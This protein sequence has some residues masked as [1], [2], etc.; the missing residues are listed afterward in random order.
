M[1][2][3]TT[4][5]PYLR[6]VRLLAEKTNLWIILIATIVGVGGLFLLW[7]SIP[8]TGESPKIWQIFAQNI[9]V[10]LIV[11]V[12]ITFLWEFLGKRAFLNEILAKTRMAEEVRLAGIIG[13]TDSFH[14]IDMTYWESLFRNA[15]HLD[16]FFAYGHTWRSIHRQHLE[17]VVKKDNAQIRVVLPDPENEQ[18]VLE[19]ARRFNYPPNKVKEFIREAEEDFRKLRQST[20][21]GGAKVNIWFLPAT[22]QFTFY[23]FDNVAILALYTHCS[24]RV[25]VPAFIVE[26]GGRLYDFIR[27]EFNAM[28]DPNNGLAQL[29]TKEQ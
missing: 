23:R 5:T 14:N 24:E 3:N 18:V 4:K 13:F 25:P 20:T 28:I 9:G 7:F 11:T 6:K 12:S 10:L 17:E 22:P 21:D 26:Q 19:L 27:K 1:S 2:G 29:I 8:P 15:S 16:I